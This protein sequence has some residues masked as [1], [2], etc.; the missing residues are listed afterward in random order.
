[1][2]TFAAVANVSVVTA[3][4]T[5]QYPG[6]VDIVVL[7]GKTGCCDDNESGEKGRHEILSISG[8]LREQRVRIVK[9]GRLPGK[10]G[11]LASMPTSLYDVFVFHLQLLPSV[12]MNM[13]FD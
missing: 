8:E 13:V 6:G 11:G 12:R 9:I 5:N 3:G 1:M 10:S 2:E 7:F 4:S